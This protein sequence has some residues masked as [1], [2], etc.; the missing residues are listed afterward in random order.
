MILGIILPFNDQIVVA[1]DCQ[2]TGHAPMA[3]YQIALSTDQQSWIPVK[4]V[5]E[6]QV[7]ITPADLGWERFEDGETYYVS[8]RGVNKAGIELRQDEAG[9]T[10]GIKV[11]SSPP[12]VGD[13]RIIHPDQYTTNC[14][15]I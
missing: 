12:V 6:K 4:D 8:I 5:T 9:V 14:F 3:Y 2:Q 11:D 10:D 15:K 7:V 13:L 1:W